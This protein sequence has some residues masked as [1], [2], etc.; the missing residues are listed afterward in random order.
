GVEDETLACGTGAVAS[1]MVA[2]SQGKTTSPVTL[3]A[4]G[5]QL[6]VSFDG[7]GPFKNVILQGPAVFVFNGT[8]DL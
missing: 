3:Q 2:V 8:I 7:T 5:G 6:T 4:L 1:A